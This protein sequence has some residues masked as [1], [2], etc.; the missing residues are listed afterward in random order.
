[1]SPSTD[2]FLQTALEIITLFFLLI[3][4]VGLIFPIFPGLTIMWFATLIYAII[5]WWGDKMTGWDWFLFAIITILMIVGNFADNVI[6]ASKMRDHYIPWSSIIIAFTAGILVSI[7]LTPLVGLLAAPLALFLAEWYRLKDRWAAFKSTKVYMI[8][9]GWAFG[10]R[11]IIGIAII[12]SWM[13]WA[14]L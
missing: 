1:M 13:A 2:L 8:G 14:W 7:F 9:W 12:G 3:G 4:L 10:V 6:I 5:Q 11:F